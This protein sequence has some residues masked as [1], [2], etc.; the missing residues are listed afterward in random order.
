MTTFIRQGSAWWLALAALVALAGCADVAPEG[1]DKAPDTIYQHVEGWELLQLALPVE[2][3]H[4]Y[5][6]DM[7]ADGPGMTV[8][9]PSGSEA[10]RVHFDMLQTE[11]GYDWV[12]I[13]DA[14][15]QRVQRLTGRFQG[16]SQEI[17]GDMARV[18]LV[19]DYSVTGYGFHINAIQYRAP[20]APS[21]GEWV[22]QN[23]VGDAIIR[24]A[25]PYS[26]H[27]MVKWTVRA[28]PEAT[29]IRLNF[30]DFELERGYD[31]AFLYDG[32]GHQVATYTGRRGDFT[33]VE[34]EGNVVTVELV[35]DYSVTG[36]GFEVLTYEVLVDAAGCG[37]DADCGP[38][39][40]C[41]QVQC[42]RWP[43]PAQCIPV[44]TACEAD[45]DCA[46][47]DVCNGGTCE[48]L[49]CA[50]I[51]QPV[52][53]EDGQTYGNACEA[54]LNHVAVAHEGEC[55]ALCGVFR[56]GPMT[57]P[58]GD[59]CHYELNATCGWADAPG[60]CREIPQVCTREFMPVCGCDGNTYGNSCMANAAGTSVL[61]AGNCEEE[62]EPEPACH[63]AGCSG[64]LCVPVDE[65]PITT[66]EFR[67]EYA[68]LHEAACELQANGRCGFTQT[69]ELR[70][71][72]R[73]AR[74]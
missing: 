39:M 5:R 69:D 45:A 56:N 19:S 61:H 14:D 54:R 52:C 36:Y 72:L 30:N 51:Y 60:T 28:I 26:N 34:V 23:L 2:S 7:P 68:C 70:Q 21:E 11:R 29:R 25:H 41:E 10:F 57:C 50:E 1:D 66:C 13:F 18:V 16:W 22:E 53:G 64:Q 35:T 71:C 15:G 74:R 3:A 55:R 31:F 8:R 47:G 24:T 65:N 4:P 12:D 59:Y 37:S 33:S 58:E 32:N 17:R 62:P 27:T 49:F 67:P 44:E 38:G 73:D 63:R 42:I 48:G 6:N 40:R 20:E 9:A 46:I 43:C